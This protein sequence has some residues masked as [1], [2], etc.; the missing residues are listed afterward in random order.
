[1]IT[2]VDTK[3]AAAAREQKTFSERRE[4]TQ[5]LLTTWRIKSFFRISADKTVGRDAGVDTE[6]SHEA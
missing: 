4:N 5:R 2:Q 1:M 6:N 3:L